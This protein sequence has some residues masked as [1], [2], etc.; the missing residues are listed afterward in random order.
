MKIDCEGCEYNACTHLLRR[1]STSQSL[2]A[3]PLCD[4]RQIYLELHLST[5]MG[6]SEETAEAQVGALGHQLNRHGFVRFA[7][8]R[9]NPLTVVGAKIDQDRVPVALKRRGVDPAACCYVLQFVQRGAKACG[10]ASADES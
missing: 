1:S 5:T 9:P 2:T 8:D 3:S 10:R 6:L 7:L 4:V